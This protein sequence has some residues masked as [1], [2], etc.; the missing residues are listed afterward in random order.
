MI[1]G[2]FFSPVYMNLFCRGVDA[3]VRIILFPLPSWDTAKSQI[4]CQGFY[5]TCNSETSIWLAEGGQSNA[6]DLQNT[7]LLAS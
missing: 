5:D 1:P 3:C 7:Q 4:I 2:D 6:H